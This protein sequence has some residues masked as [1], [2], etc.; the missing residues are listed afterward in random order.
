MKGPSFP[1]SPLPI[2]SGL[3]SRRGEPRPGRGR[4]PI[5]RRPVAAQVRLKSAEEASLSLLTF[6]SSPLPLV[7]RR[8]RFRPLDEVKPRPLPQTVGCDRGCQEGSVHPCPDPWATA[9]R[10]P[11]RDPAPASAWLLVGRRLGRAPLR[12][13][14]APSSRRPS[15][16]PRRRPPKA[17]L[18]QARRRPSFRRRL[19]GPARARGR[20]SLGVGHGSHWPGPTAGALPAANHDAGPHRGRRPGQPCK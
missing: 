4:T 12:V 18:L 2:P 6:S 5:V 14:E 20:C 19:P 10:R 13:P 17:R 8:R 1:S 15:M 3:I 16:G 9:T 7:S 11:P